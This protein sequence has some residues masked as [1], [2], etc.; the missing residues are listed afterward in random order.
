[1]SEIAF[2]TSFNSQIPPWSKE[3]SSDT[4]TSIRTFL[5][6]KLKMVGSASKEL[7]TIL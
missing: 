1:M 2:R 7:D 4:Q 3:E 6:L 5:S